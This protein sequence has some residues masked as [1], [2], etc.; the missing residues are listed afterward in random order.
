MNKIVSHERGM[1]WQLGHNYLLECTG[2][3]ALGGAA[4]GFIDSDYMLRLLRNF[5]LI[6]S[7]GAILYSIERHKRTKISIQENSYIQDY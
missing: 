7:I 3:I 2:I 4:G 1:K 5:D 6:G